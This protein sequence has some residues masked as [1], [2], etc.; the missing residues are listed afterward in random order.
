MVECP[1]KATALREGPAQDSGTC[2]A[3]LAFLYPVHPVDLSGWPGA[4]DHPDTG[5]M[6]CGTILD[7]RSPEGQL[8]SHSD[9][10]LTPLTGVDPAAHGGVWSGVL[11]QADGMLLAR[12]EAVEAA[13]E[14]SPL[15]NMLA[16]MGV[17]RRSTA[18]GDLGVT[19]TVLG[20]CETL[21][22]SLCPS[23]PTALHSRIR[24]GDMAPR[25]AVG[26]SARAAP[27]T[28]PAP[29]GGYSR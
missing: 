19:A 1:F 15:Q 20:Y 26:G 29:I 23:P 8:Q 22:Q 14:D 24:P 11:D 5:T 27:R 17:A 13:G 28:G 2:A 7:Y 6:P 18:E 9:L 25:T 10:W 12:V 4:A 3:W 21:T 16:M